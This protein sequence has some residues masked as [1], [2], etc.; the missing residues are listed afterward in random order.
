MAENINNSPQE[1][2]VSI[3]FSDFFEN[4]LYYR[5]IFFIVSGFVFAIALIYAL[6]ATPIYKADV[7]IQVEDKKSSALSGALQNVSGALEMQS[8]PVAGQMEI[9]KSRNIVG[10]AVESLFL[11]TS[12]SVENRI[13]MVSGLVYRFL[14]K[15]P[16]GLA[17]PPVNWIDYAWGGE[18]LVF[19]SYIIPQI[20]LRKPLTLVVAEGG[21]W[22]LYDEEDILLAKGI[23]GINTVSDD[24]KWLINIKSLKANPGT[25]FELIQY[26]LQSRISQIIPRLKTEETGKQSGLFRVSFEDE[27]PYF[28][29]R[30]LN[31]ISQS[32]VD[33]NTERKAEET[34]KT[35]K[36]LNKKLPELA[37]RMDE[38]E[39]AFSDFRNRE[40]TIDVPG[41][42]K[43]LLDRAVAIETQRLQAEIKRS[44]MSQRYQSAHPYMKAVN[45]QLA[46]LKAE[47]KSIESEISALPETQREYLKYARDAEI[48]SKLYSS[49]LDT[50]QQLQV[51]KAGTV[52]NVFIIDSAIAPERAARPNKILIVAGGAVIAILLG[53]IAANVLAYL[54][55]N[56][57]DPKK[58]EDKSGIKMFS[59]LPLSEEQKSFD[60]SDATHSHLLAREKPNSMVVEG[61][62]SLRIAIQFGLMSKPKRK[63]ILITSAVPGQGKSFISANLAYLMACSDKKVLLVDADIRKTSLKHYFAF[64]KNEGLTDYLQHKIN[65]DHILNKDFYPRLDIISAGKTVRNP[66]ELLLDECFKALIEWAENL[67]DY[68][69]ID[70]PP[71]LAVNDAIV[72]SKIVDMTLFVAR[73]DFVNFNEINQSLESLYKIGV[74]PDG[75]VF[76]GYT[77]SMI[78]YGTRYGYGYGR[79]GR[80]G[81]YGDP[82]NENGNEN[83]LHQKFGVSYV[84]RKVIHFFYVV[85]IKLVKIFKSIRR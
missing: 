40:T 24:G 31:A 17:I 35:L 41:E 53:V 58:L 13:P 30:L 12:V 28:A 62:R 21:S 81:R 48:S 71:V 4:I 73:Q 74:T 15:T 36:F 8:S 3:S 79:Y 55:G 49:L 43:A 11:N 2:E 44:E 26:S 16:D 9:F 20:Y 85:Q 65:I 38:A 82:D 60:E 23:V 59:I 64:E 19:D 50:S 75:M 10:R 72:V 77:P 67:Y 69:V 1:D 34:D 29:Q 6:F 51:T 18:D 7:L 14:N 5:K 52:G 37:D 39:S 45:S 78:K 27:N 57:R 25:Q 68:V 70:S 61:L 80:Y 56:V 54:L 46:Q 32:Y 84:S 47:N 42:I 83:D 76:N 66:G 63:V 33:Q 22:N